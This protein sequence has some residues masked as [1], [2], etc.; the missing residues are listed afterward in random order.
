MVMLKPMPV[1][2]FEAFVD[3]AARSHAADNVASGRWSTHESEQLARSDLLRMLPQGVATPDHYLY[4]VLAETDGPTVGFL[5]LGSM[6]RG[7]SKVA[8]V[9]QIFIHP[10]HRRQGHARATL[11]QV[12]DLARSW[13]LPAIALNVFGSNAGAQALYRSMGYAVTSLTMQKPLATSP[14]A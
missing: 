10:E 9:F 3:A 6:S 4:E 8:F 2:Q 14:V 11:L 5:W 7:T 13:G 1:D 12:E